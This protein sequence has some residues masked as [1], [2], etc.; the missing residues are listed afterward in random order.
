M[1]EGRVCACVRGTHLPVVSHSFANK[2]GIVDDVEV[3]QGGALWGASCA[4]VTD[5]RKHHC[6]QKAVKRFAN[7]CQVYS[8]RLLLLLSKHTHLI[9]RCFSVC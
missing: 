5:I 9:N 6:I 8:D 3:R 7:V 2:V 1:A 4:L